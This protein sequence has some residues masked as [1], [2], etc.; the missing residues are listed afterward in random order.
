M[1]VAA[2]A[3]GFILTGVL[4]LFLWTSAAADDGV[5]PA[6]STSTAPVHLPPSPAPTSVRVWFGN[7]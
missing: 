2:T 5:A 1:K 6:P 3:L 7:R 4:S